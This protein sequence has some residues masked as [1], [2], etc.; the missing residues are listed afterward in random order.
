MWREDAG[1]VTFCLAFARCCQRSS[2]LLQE[3]EGK[4][5]RNEKGETA[6][7]NLPCGTASR[8]TASNPSS[9]GSIT[10]QATDKGRVVSE[11][12]D[13]TKTSDSQPQIILVCQ[14]L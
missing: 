10:R 6:L 9:T 8:W 2:P 11:E 13:T 1:S 7:R 12:A 3:E 14:G 5:R 4:G